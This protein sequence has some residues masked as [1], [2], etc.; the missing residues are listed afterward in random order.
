MK[1][2]T[3]LKGFTLIEILVVISIIGILAAVLL[4][5]LLGARKRAADTKRK[6]ALSQ[7][8][9]ALRLYYNDHQTYPD[10]ASE[11]NCNDSA[12]TSALSSYIDSSAIPVGCRYIDED[13]GNAFSAYVTL[14]ISAGSDDTDSATR[15]G[16][17]EVEQRYYVCSK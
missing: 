11:T 12:I 7:L 1:K 2:I 10:V 15:C 17:S 6:M 9:S 3:F 8:K 16:K 4:P 13:S 5:N 14:Q